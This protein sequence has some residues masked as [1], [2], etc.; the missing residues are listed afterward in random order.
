MQGLLRL[1]AIR[2]RWRPRAWP[3]G[4]GSRGFMDSSGACAVHAGRLLCEA[5]NRENIR[6]AEECY[7]EGSRWDSWTWS[8]AVPVA[9]VVGRNPTAPTGLRVRRRAR[10][11]FR[12]GAARDVLCWARV[13]PGWMV[14]PPR[15]LTHNGKKM[16]RYSVTLL[17]PIKF[18]PDPAPPYR[19]RVL[20]GKIKV[21][22]QIYSRSSVV[23]SGDR[24]SAGRV[25]ARVPGPAARRHN[26]A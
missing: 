9:V 17:R 23:T 21:F 16:L 7:G 24:S 5:P 25:P 8:K 18:D 11:F 15:A 10:A 13:S 19:H 12:Q 14:G 20:G 3:T 22:E 1:A 26:P 2:H 6:A 4:A